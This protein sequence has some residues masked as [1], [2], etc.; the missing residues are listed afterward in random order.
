[1]K[2]MLIADAG[3]SKTSWSFI[4]E[5]TKEVIRFQTIGI[6]PAHDSRETV[7]SVFQEI[8]NKISPCHVNEIHYY[9]AGC[10][11]P[12]LNNMVKSSLSYVFNTENITVESDLKGAYIALFGNQDGITCILGTGSASALFSKGEIID[13]TPSL[14]FILG[15]EGSG[16][17]LGKNLLNAVFKKQFSDNVIKKFQERYKLSL[18]EL[19]EKVYKDPKPAPF[20]A[21]FSPFLL[22]CIQEKEVQLIVEKEFENFFKKN[23]QNYQDSRQYNIGFVGS[24]AFNYKDILLKTAEKFGW[25]IDKILK[26]PLPSIEKY[27]LDH[28]LK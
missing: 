19:I 15:D 14:G 24:V 5:K 27:Y 11:T 10:A 1:M 26:D 4:N 23:V 28:F 16:V 8:K 7:I 3:S 21:S 25:Q 20:I 17:A 12:L 22:E 2:N 6:N 9:G 18:S 13:R